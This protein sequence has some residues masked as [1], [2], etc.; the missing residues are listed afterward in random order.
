MQ[1]ICTRPSCVYINLN[2]NSDDTVFGCYENSAVNA[3][4]NYLPLQSICYAGIVI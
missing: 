4:R 3:G 2:P 1:I